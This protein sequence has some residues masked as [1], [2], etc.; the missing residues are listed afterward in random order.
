MTVALKS[1][2]EVEIGPSGGRAGWHCL[3]VPGDPVEIRDRKTRRRLST[4][5]PG[6]RSSMFLGVNEKRS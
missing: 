1:A 6:E 4:Q 2:G 3:G 5:G